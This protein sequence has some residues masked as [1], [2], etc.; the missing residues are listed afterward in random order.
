MLWPNYMFACKKNPL[1]GGFE[2]GDDVEQF[3]IYCASTC[4]IEFSLHLLFELANII[5]S[6]LHSSEPALAETAR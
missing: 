6:S 3:V 5:F 1:N 4:L 2:T